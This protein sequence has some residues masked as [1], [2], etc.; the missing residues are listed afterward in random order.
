MYLSYY[1]LN[2]FPFSLSCEGKYFYE[3]S[4]HR[5]ALGNMLYAIQQRKGMV[6]ITGEVG[7]G[8]SFVGNM[9]RS[10]LGAGC[11]AAIIQNPPESKKQLL[12][13][14]AKQIGIKARATMDKL[15]LEENLQEFLIRLHSRGRLVGLILDEAQELSK[16]S[17]EEIRLLWNWEQDG[18]RLIQIVLIGQPELRDKLQDPK[19]EPL[20]QRIVLSYHLSSLTAADTIAYIHHRLR[21]AS[22][23]GATVEFSPEALEA[24]HAATDGIPRLINTLC[25]NALLVGYVKG[26]EHIDKSIVMDVLRDMTCW[27]LQVSKEDASAVKTVGRVC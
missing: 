4:V 23:N 8:K 2:E 19:W 17:L 12:R 13:S 11:L 24:I 18:Q 27:G 15:T 7:T 20:R 5:E 16:T 10:R 14:F 22:S 26:M 25:D 6:L 1:K 21:I 3:S 9:L